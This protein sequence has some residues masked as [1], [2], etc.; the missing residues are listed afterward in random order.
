VIINV[1]HPADLE[2][3]IPTG[4]LSWKSSKNI[5]LDH[6][7]S[8]KAYEKSR[9]YQ[10]LEGWLSKGLLLALNGSLDENY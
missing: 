1:F 6:T 10:Y 7:V 5:I 2:V 4:K 9:L 3:L 8:K